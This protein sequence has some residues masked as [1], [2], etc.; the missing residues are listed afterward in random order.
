MNEEEVHNPEMCT[1][2]AWFPSNAVVRQCLGQAH[3]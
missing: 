3:A 1:C 2:A